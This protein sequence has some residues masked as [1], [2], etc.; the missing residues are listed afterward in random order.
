MRLV[1]LA[2]GVLLASGAIWAGTAAAPTVALGGQIYIHPTASNG[3]SGTI[4]VVGAIGDHG[5]TLTID[6]NGKTDVNGNFVKVTLEKGTF[7][8]NS[9]ALNAKMS[10]Q[11]P[12]LNKTTCSFMMSGSSRV[13][14]FNGTGL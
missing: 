13:G 3:P 1:K 10:K 6:K 11:Q 12:M 2:S 9:T 7:E 8:V 14:V 5:T 4:V